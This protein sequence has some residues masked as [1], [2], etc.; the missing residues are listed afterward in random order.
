LASLASP[1]SPQV[2]YVPPRAAKVREGGGEWGKGRERVGGQAGAL[3][4]GKMA[5]ISKAHPEHMEWWAWRHSSKCPLPGCQVTEVVH[6]VKLNLHPM[7][8]T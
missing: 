6:V 8:H 7:H 3:L 2:P 1:S 5:H 4:V